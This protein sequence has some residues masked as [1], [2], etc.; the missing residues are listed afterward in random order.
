MPPPP[1]ASG[2]GSVPHAWNSDP[3]EWGNGQSM[4]GGIEAEMKGNVGGCPG[5]MPHTPWGG[6][7]APLSSTASLQTPQPHGSP[8][9]PTF[10][11]SP[12]AMSR[13]AQSPSPE[14]GPCH[15]RAPRSPHPVPPTWRL[16]HR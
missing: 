14:R 7:G 2:P 4:C 15:P 12:R 1:P 6:T 9:A 8:P 13:C 3:L 16:R 5:P 10:S 11:S